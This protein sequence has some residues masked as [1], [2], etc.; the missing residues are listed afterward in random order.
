[1]AEIVSSLKEDELMI[2]HADDSLAD[3]V[4]I[5]LRRTLGAS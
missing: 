3:G 1:M 2:L 4:R 5:S